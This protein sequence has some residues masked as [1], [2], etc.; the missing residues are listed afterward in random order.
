VACHA[1][2]AVANG[3]HARPDWDRGLFLCALF[4]AL[5]CL[6]LCCY[7]IIAST[8]GRVASATVQFCQTDFHFSGHFVRHQTRCVLLVE[9]LGERE[10]DT[11]GP[12]KAGDSVRVQILRGQVSDARLSH[13]QFW[14][15]APVPVLV[16]LLARKGWPSAEKWR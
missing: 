11:A 1:F 10:V 3:R 16:M 12:H 7:A 5:L 9:H 4:L 8:F 13:A 14:F 2:R 6:G 15:L